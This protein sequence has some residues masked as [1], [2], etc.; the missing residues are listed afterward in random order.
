MRYAFDLDGCLDRPAIRLL[1]RGLVD[2][3]NEV[4]IL[5]GVWPEGDWQSVKAKQAKL[6]E[7]DLAYEHPI[8]GFT[9]KKGFYIF[10][11][12]PNA[13]A[14]RE[15]RLLEI[16]FQKGDYCR[17]LNISVMFDDSEHY[18]KHMPA[19]CGTQMVQVR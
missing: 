18:I 13:A 10:M 15:D 17:R 19:F 6:I 11:A 2:A 14:P 5:S 3:G 12:A 1:A 4:H 9:M 8:N 7:M 16:A